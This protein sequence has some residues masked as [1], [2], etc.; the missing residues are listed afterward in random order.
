[1]LRPRSARNKKG[2]VEDITR[3]LFGFILSESVNI[4]RTSC[5]MCAVFRLLLRTKVLFV[6]F[7]N[8]IYSRHLFVGAVRFCRSAV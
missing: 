2:D 5:Q 6:R 4:Q 3:R 1:M 7:G 8:N